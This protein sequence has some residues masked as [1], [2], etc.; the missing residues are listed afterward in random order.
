MYTPRLTRL[1]LTAIL[2][3][4]GS[5]LLSAQ[6]KI[7]VVSLQKALQDTAEIKQ[8]EGELKARFGPR[9]DEL[10]KMEK[11]IA[12]LEQ[13]YQQ[14]QTKYTEAA[15]AELTGRI[16]TRQRQFQRNSQALQDDVNS[17]RQE[18]LSRVGQR[19]QEVIKKVAEEKALDM[20]VEAGNTYFYRPTLEITADVTA[21]YDKAYPVKK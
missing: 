18:V 19:L 13:D 10:A 17:V 5:G 3:F 16:Q 7:G 6:A 1:A 4:L 11:E 21:A 14:N 20:V 2:A 12:K 15:L 8:A 9:Q